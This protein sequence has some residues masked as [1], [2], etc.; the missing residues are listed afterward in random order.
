MLSFNLS[1]QDRV[2]LHKRIASSHIEPREL[3]TMSSTDLASEE[4]KEIIRQAE[5]EALAHSI[6]KKTLLPRAKITH[7]GLEDIEDVNDAARREE[8]EREQEEEE[9]IERER[10][11][12]DADDLEGGEAR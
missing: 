11:V 9:R 8:R 2:V 12:M 5:Q 6:L 4:A 10:Q 7:K 1:K 3:A